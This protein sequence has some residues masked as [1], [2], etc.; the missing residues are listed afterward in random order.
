MGWTFKLVHPETGE[1]LHGDTKHFQNDADVI[2]DGTTELTFNI[3]T[4]YDYVIEEK[5]AFE[6]DYSPEDIQPWTLLFIKRD[7]KFG[8]T[9]KT[10]EETIPILKEIIGYLSDDVGDGDY[11]SAAEGNVKKALSILLTFATERPDGVWQVS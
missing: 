11:W 7:I 6:S 3:T 5:L 10:G 1:I 4:N 9:W 8:N 2:P